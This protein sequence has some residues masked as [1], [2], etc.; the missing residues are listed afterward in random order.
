MFKNKHYV[1]WISSLLFAD[2]VVFI[3]PSSQD[4]QHV[5]GQFTAK[6]EAAGVRISTSKSEAMALDRKKVSCSFRVGGEFLPQVEEFKYLI[7]E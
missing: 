1:C 7:H 6:C 4:L 2:D 5:L 3:A